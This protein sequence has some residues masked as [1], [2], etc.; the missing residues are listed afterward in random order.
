M[1]INLP[2]WRTALWTLVKIDRKED[3]DQLDV[4]S[5]WLI[6]T[7]SGVTVVT[8]YSCII[9]G[10]LAWRDGYFSFLPW[11]IITLVL[12]PGSKYKL[13]SAPISLDKA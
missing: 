1:K 6:A 2:M 5:K 8:I 13:K 12:C 4:I 10:L 11:V 3:W 9:A 7:R